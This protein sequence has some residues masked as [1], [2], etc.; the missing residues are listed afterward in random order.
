MILLALT[1]RSAITGFCTTGMPRISS[2][3]MVCWVIV[4]DAYPVR[5]K[6]PHKNRKSVFISIPLERRARKNRTH[7]RVRKRDVRKD[8]GEKQ[9]RWT[10]T[11]FY[12][13]FSAWRVE[14]FIGDFF[15]C[16]HSLYR[17]MAYIYDLCGRACKEQ[18]NALLE[19][20]G[21]IIF[22][23]GSTGPGTQRNSG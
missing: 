13:P 19:G 21:P 12:F 7:S 9:R 15:C 3:R 17:S 8:F 22:S 1:S 18:L 16:L 11:A 6:T 23:H 4:W 10:C 14:F 2:V 5:S 20:V